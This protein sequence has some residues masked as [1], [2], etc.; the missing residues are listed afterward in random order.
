MR[1]WNASVRA[2]AAAALLLL[3]AVPLR[4]NEVLRW[5]RVATDA[6]A[7]AR[8]DPFTESRASGRAGSPARTAAP[9]PT[10]R[11]PS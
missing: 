8:T 4:A 11:R 5:N 1:T 7:R 2:A 9:R 3:A 10:S 6:A